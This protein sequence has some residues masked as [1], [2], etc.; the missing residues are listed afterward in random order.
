MWEKR[1]WSILVIV[2]IGVATWW[3]DRQTEEL[4][5]LQVEFAA[6]QKYAEGKYIQKELIL[7]IQQR[8]SKRLEEIERK[9]DSLT[10]EIDRRGR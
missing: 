10:R 3:V 4:H 9:L 2:L 5:K 8:N 1:A 6:Y 7:N